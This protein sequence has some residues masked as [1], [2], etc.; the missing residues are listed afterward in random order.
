MR[1]AFCGKGGSGK[2]TLSTLFTSW[3]ESQNIPVLAFDG[4]INQHLGVGLGFSKEEIDN[5]RKIGVDQK[6]LREYIRGSNKS[7][8]TIDDILETTPPGTGSKF[9]RI[10]DTENEVYEQFSLTRGSLRFLALGGHTLD[11]TATTCYHKYTAAMGIF[12]NH[13]IDGPGEYMVGDLVAGADPFASS[14]LSTRYDLRILAVEPTQ[15]S[16]EVYNQA[17]EYLKPAGLGVKVV[18]NKVMDEQDLDYI[19]AH[20]GD[21]LIGAMPFSSYIRRLDRGE[22]LDAGQF[23]DEMVTLLSTIKSLVDGIDRDWKRYRELGLQFHQIAS[24]S[25]AEDWIG[26]DPMT[27]VDKTFNYQD[28]V[29]GQHA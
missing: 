8:R 26:I 16:L 7:I 27:Q 13:L 29:N 24:E 14:S 17:I 12:L 1:V 18:A 22:K 3:L 4:D 10:T 25:W 19:K 28:V 15:K 9:F 6:L 11:E 2:T 5:Q 23:S 20:V 21:D